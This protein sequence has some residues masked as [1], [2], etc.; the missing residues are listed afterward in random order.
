M[1]ADRAQNREWLGQGEA[2]FLAQVAEL[3]DEQFAEPSALP[4]WS[5]AHVV[6][7]VAR[8]AEAVGRLLSWAATGVES[9]MYPDSETRD[10]DIA[11]TAAVQPDSLREDARATSAELARQLDEL[12]E[13][14]WS[15]G[16]QTFQGRD[17]SA[18]QTL[19]MRIREVWLHA[20]DLGAG[21]FVESWP[22]DLIEA[23]LADVTTSMSAKPD[24]PAV[25]LIG[26]DPEQTWSIGEPGEGSQEVSG[27]AADL[28]AWLTG[29]SAGDGL[30]TSGLLPGLPHW[31]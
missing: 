7:H 12:P 21:S 1:P 28:L 16:V 23:C 11:R 25:R 19:W 3:D 24:A 26:T 17:I 2:H 27:K 4:D 22:A 31:M 10:A 15:A 18:E 30:S 14:A 6:A 5:R 8:N 20:V 29:R 13:A 9:R